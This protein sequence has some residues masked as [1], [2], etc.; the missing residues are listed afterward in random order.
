MFRDGILTRLPMVN[1][2]PFQSTSYLVS[3]K[4]IFLHLQVPKQWSVGD[5]G[6]QGKLEKDSPFQSS[7]R[8]PRLLTLDPWDT[9][10]PADSNHS[11]IGVISLYK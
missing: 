9:V 8:G 11:R 4:H 1:L 10:N 2:L 5:D 6:I 3:I 7:F